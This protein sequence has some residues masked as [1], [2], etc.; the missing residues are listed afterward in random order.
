[1]K[2][3][4]SLLSPQT[5]KCANNKHHFRFKTQRS[6]FTPTVGQRK[7]F[8]TFSQQRRY[9]DLSH[10]IG[11]VA[12]PLLA[13]T[14]FIS[15]I[16]LFKKR[17]FASS[18]L[19]SEDKWLKTMNKNFPKQTASPSTD[20]TLYSLRDVEYIPEDIAE[21]PAPQFPTRY[22]AKLH[23]FELGFPE[24]LIDEELAKFGKLVRVDISTTIENM[25][26]K[27][28]VPILPNFNRNTYH[29]INH[30]TLIVRDK[31]IKDLKAK[32]KVGIVTCLQYASNPRNIKGFRKHVTISLLISAIFPP[33]IAST[34]FYIPGSYLP[35]DLYYQYP[36]LISIAGTL[37]MTYIV[38]NSS[39]FI[40]S[41]L[42]YG[43][44]KKDLI[45]KHEIFERLQ[46]QG[47][48]ISIS[49]TS[50]GFIP[51]I[52][53][54]LEMMDIF[55]KKSGK[56]EEI[57]NSFGSMFNGAPSSSELI[58]PFKIIY[59]ERNDATSAYLIWYF[60]I[61]L[62]LAF[63]PEILDSDPSE[64]EGKATLQNVATSGINKLKRFI[65]LNS[66]EIN[67]EQVVEDENSS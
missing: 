58:P 45:K 65:G 29:I 6:T 19:M 9:S 49:R 46:L 8:P 42:N 34:L 33:L 4:K 13:G 12:I 17:I 64:L 43:D 37:L 50:F 53:A 62:L 28:A 38:M 24:N 23:L 26:K 15:T 30:N 3:T 5:I 51:N 22:E 66:D 21:Q 35:V 60:C 2:G 61:F 27:Q 18:W 31:A 14:S 55:Y 36:F 40:D 32:G 48:S 67:S 41:Y 11:D 59:Y 52:P 25:L 10:A 1:M 56:S 20:I 63:L 16:L 47:T 39:L 57:V 7:L 44:I 54:V